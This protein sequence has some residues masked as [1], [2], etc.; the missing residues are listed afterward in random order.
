MEEPEPVYE[1]SDFEQNLENS[2]ESVETFLNREDADPFSA[3]I[4]SFK[5]QFSEIPLFALPKEMLDDQELLKFN[6][7]FDDTPLFEEPFLELEE[8]PYSFFHIGSLLQEFEQS[9]NTCIQLKQR[10]YDLLEKQFDLKLE[11]QE[12]EKLDK[13]HQQEV[14]SGFYKLPLIKAKIDYQSAAKEQ[15]FF[16]EAY[17][18]LISYK[19]SFLTSDYLMTYK[20]SSEGTAYMSALP[21]LKK[22][23]GQTFRT[24]PY[25]YN[26]ISAT[27]TPSKWLKTFVEHRH[28]F[29]M[30]GVKV[31]NFS[32][33][34]SAAA[35]CDAAHFRKENAK[36]AIEWALKD[37]EFRM[38][39]TLVARQS[40]DE[41]VAQSI[42]AGSHMNYPEQIERLSSRYRLHYMKLRGLCQLI[43]YG[44][45]KVHGLESEIFFEPELDDLIEWYEYITSDLRNLLRYEQGFVKTVIID[46]SEGRDIDSESGFVNLSFEVKEGDLLGAKNVKMMGLSAY[47]S[48]E[49]EGNWELRIS[50]PKESFFIRP[51]N[52]KSSINQSWL[53]SVIM[54]R[55]NTR[56]PDNP[57]DIVGISALKNSSPLGEWKLQ[58]NKQSSKGIGL[59]RLSSLELDFHLSGRIV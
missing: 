10:M 52:T 49:S 46:L 2:L 54:G 8:L 24:V 21:Y 51:H 20:D 34:R 38:S 26:D 40:M 58:I 22:E 12:F 48:G 3:S 15:K 32:A 13:I 44:V 27:K 29:Q 11:I 33:H 25:Q 9:L 36:A 1:D 41:K 59:E 7:D 19:S 45:Y 55:V 14:D 56:E 37:V 42:K 31:S 57:A 23:S 28:R 47:V 5:S 30:E 43:G 39:R 35:N 50:P 17:D 4:G 53:P 18:K 6:S 16:R